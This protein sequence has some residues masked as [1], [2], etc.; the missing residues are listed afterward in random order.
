MATNAMTPS[1]S[2]VATDRPR[3]PR[4]ILYI[5]PVLL[6]LSLWAYSA[7]KYDFTPKRF[8]VVVPSQIYRSGQ[9]S[10]RMLKPT[11]QQYNIKTIVDFQGP[12]TDPDTAM[13]AE[14]QICKELNIEHHRFPLSG[15]GTGPIERYADALITI[16][17]AQRANK[18]VLIHCSAG[19]QRTGAATAFYR[20]LIEKKP[21]A[22]AYAE[23][24]RYDW[25]PEKDAV[26]ITYINDHLAELAQLLV[27]RGVIPEVPNPLPRIGP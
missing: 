18:P 16:V 6:G 20:L 14:Q 17:T 8:G 3:L 23:L 25:N 13:D 7:F 5:L 1:T 10:P 4:L 21:P 26:L 2:I 22:E 11:L 9:L 12:K 19:T 24:T 15:D 27:T